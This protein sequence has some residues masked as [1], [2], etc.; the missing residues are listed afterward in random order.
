MQKQALVGDLQHT[1]MKQQLHWRNICNSLSLCSCDSVHEL[2][3]LL[4]RCI[5]IPYVYMYYNYM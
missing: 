3:D 4:A 1:A 2:V 5:N